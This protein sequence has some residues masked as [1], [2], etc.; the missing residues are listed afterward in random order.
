MNDPKDHLAQTLKDLRQSLKLSLDKTSERTG[1]SKAMLGQIERG[2]SSP[3]ISTVWKIATGLNVPITTFIEAPAKPKKATDTI[4]R[5]ADE[6]QRSTNEGSFQIA[7]LFKFDPDLGFEYMELTFQGGYES[8]SDPHEPGVIE[9]MTITE[10]A[11][12]LH[13]DGAWLPLKTGDTVRYA[14]DKPHA[15]RNPF[16]TPC[17][18]IIVIH[19]PNRMA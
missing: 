15:Y 18:A 11:M 9:I 19:Y 10:G 12:E 6:I 16:N 1:V 5:R 2:E 3:T 8:H 7:P 4:I 17:K 13:A 14:G